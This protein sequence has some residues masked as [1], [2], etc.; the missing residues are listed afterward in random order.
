MPQLSVVIITY[1][2]ESHIAQCIGSV[3]AV[4]DEII[5]LDSYSSDQTAVIARSLGATVYQEK[6]RGY[7]D[8]KNL[9][10]QLAKND[11]V[12]SLD[13]DEELDDTLTAAIL[14]EK[15]SFSARA[16]TMKRCTNFCGHFIRHGNWYPDYKLRLFDKK[17]ATW[18]GFNPHDR[19]ELQKGIEAKKLNGD[20]LHYSFDSMDDLVKQN[21]RLSSIAASSLYVKGKKTSWL[22][23]L[24]NPTW[25]FINGYLL[26][27][28][29]LDGADGFF[30]AIHNAHYVF[31]KHSKLYHLWQKSK[32]THQNPLVKS[33]KQVSKQATGDGK[34]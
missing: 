9:A 33:I 30:I 21:Y 4:A 2:E 15:K 17:I 16:Y 20:I 11:Y 32:D 5:V 27:G 24:I 3:R 29:F 1:N 6:F 7:I 8:Q 19:I 18:G 26:R 28:G 22:K 10:L 14:E 23:L 34:N 12:L 25:A 13:A 31:Q